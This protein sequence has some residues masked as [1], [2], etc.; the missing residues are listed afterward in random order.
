MT[1]LN[2]SKNGKP[3]I[4]LADLVH[5]YIGR[6]PFMFPINIGYLKSYLQKFH[7]DSLEVRLFKYPNE[8]I[9]AVETN[10]PNIVGFSNYAWNE[11]IDAKLIRYFK[12]KF[13]NMV[14]VM[15]GPNINI[16]GFDESFEEINTDPGYLS[17]FLRSQPDLD[18]YVL[19]K[20]EPGF[21][22][23]VNSY[24]E[25]DGDVKRMK[26]SPIDFV[27]FFNKE[28]NEVEAIRG[29][30]PPFWKNLGIIPSPYLTG[31][32]DE[33][34]NQTLIPQIETDRG[35]PYPCK[36]CAWGKMAYQK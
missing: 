9:K 1:A 26:Q 25:S 22:N 4:Y 7:S 12:T 16:P 6:G 29:K 13:P 33:F 19:L 32:M 20:G 15:G 18:F 17:P 27:A 8:L 11:D 36:W 30:D 14:T 21:L 3:K 10:P 24:L 5:N 28:M 35:C 23:I 34:F 2:L 31:V